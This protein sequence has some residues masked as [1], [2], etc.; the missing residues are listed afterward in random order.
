M[1]VFLASSAPPTCKAYSDAILLHDCYAIYNA[2]PPPPPPPPRLPLCMPYTIIFYRVKANPN[3][4]Y[5]GLTRGARR[6]HRRASTPAR[7]HVSLYTIFVCLFRDC[8][9]V[10]SIIGTKQLYFA[11]LNVAPHT[12]S[13][14][15]WFPLDPPS[16]VS[17]TIQHW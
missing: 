2:P 3:P 13:R 14:D 9:L 15:V 5:L 11:P 6:R 1:G 7:S 16:C 10:N 17:G 8:A 12:I 4:V